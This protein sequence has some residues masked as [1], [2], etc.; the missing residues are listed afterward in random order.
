MRNMKTRE[1]V[2]LNNNSVSSPSKQFYENRVQ[3]KQ[4]FFSNAA[5]IKISYGSDFLI[6]Y[7]LTNT[8]PIEWEAARF[9]KPNLGLVNTKFIVTG[10]DKKAT[11]T[12]NGV[13]EGDD[14]EPYIF[15]TDDINGQSS[16]KEY[17]FIVLKEPDR[18]DLE[19]IQEYAVEGVETAISKCIAR[20]KCGSSRFFLFF[21]RQ[22]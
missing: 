8:D 14:D 10:N 1:A 22:N 19:S 12:I 17:D 2:K 7:A 20:G 4:I 3:N 13:K 5:R 21:V 9:P 15:Q 11:I 18:L 16:T 6:S